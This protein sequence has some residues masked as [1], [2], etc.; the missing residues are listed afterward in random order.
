[1]NQD[2]TARPS[3]SEATELMRPKGATLFRPA[4]SQEDELRLLDDP[5]DT[6]MRVI[7][8]ELKVAD[9]KNS[10][11]LVQLKLAS[12]S[13]AVILSLLESGLTAESVHNIIMRMKLN[14]ML[15]LARVSKS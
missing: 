1:M 8:D 13:D 5:V 12:D 10:D 9:I 6:I 4:E 7:R 3:L 11:V 15:Q 2:S 14:F